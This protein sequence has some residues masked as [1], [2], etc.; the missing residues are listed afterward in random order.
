MSL[1]EKYR[2]DALRVFITG[3]KKSLSYILFAKGPKDLP[4]ALALA[5]VVESNHERYQFALNYS[6]SLG[7]IQKAEK[8]QT[9]RDWHTDVH[10]Q[11][12]N[13]HFSLRQPVP[14]SGNQA[15]QIRH[16]AH[17]QL[18]DTDVSMRTIRTGQ[19]QLRQSPSL[20]QESVPLHQNT[21]LA[22]QQNT[23]QGSGTGRLTAPKQ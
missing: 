12:K 13:P 15:S 3:T 17:D 21:W 1:N 19:Y 7:E 14:S 11:G 2:S 23:Q 4:T 16:L 18:M 5:Q 8:K 22:Q 6:R 20:H 10:Q 9:D